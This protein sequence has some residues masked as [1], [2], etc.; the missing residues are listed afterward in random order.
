MCCE[1]CNKPG[2]F[3]MECIKCAARHCKMQLYPVAGMKEE[4]IKAVAT[5]YKHNAD[6]LLQLAMRT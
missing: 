5:K 3:N 2:L 1:V 4:Y 6:E